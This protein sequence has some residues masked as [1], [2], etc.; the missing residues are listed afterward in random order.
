MYLII[1]NLKCLQNLSYEFVVNCS[2]LIVSP[3]RKK[4]KLQEVVICAKMSDE[5]SKYNRVLILSVS[6][7]GVFR[8]QPNIDDEA[9]IRK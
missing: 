8:A 6:V 1:F 4:G 2:K 7:K 3:S 5:N 9:F